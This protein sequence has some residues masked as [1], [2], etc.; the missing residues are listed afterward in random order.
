MRIPKRFTTMLT[1]ALYVMFRIISRKFNV[2]VCI[3]T[4]KREPDEARC[5]D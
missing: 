5:R 3:E 4:R 2:N 1:I